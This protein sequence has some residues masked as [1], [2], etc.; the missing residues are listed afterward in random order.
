MKP[1]RTMQFKALLLLIVFS[2]NTIMSFACSLGLDMWYN[3]NHHKEIK[4]AESTRHCCA[5]ETAATDSKDEQN[6]PGE[7]DDCCTNSVISFQLMAQSVS[8][9]TIDFS[10]PFS[11]THH[12]FMELIYL[13]DQ[14]II[15]SAM[16]WAVFRTQQQPPPDIRVSI[17]SFQI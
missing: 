16:K 6:V 5:K 11:N 13:T 3:S 4:K 8:Q 14:S 17:R 9:L 2:L 7:K 10:L 1:N 12:E 15:S